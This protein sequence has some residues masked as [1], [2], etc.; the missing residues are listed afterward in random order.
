MTATLGKQG[1]LSLLADDAASETLVDPSGVSSLL[2]DGQRDRRF[3]RNASMPFTVLRMLDDG[4]GG[5]T[6][7]SY[8]VSP[9]NLPDD[10]VLSLKK[11]LTSL[12]GVR[13]EFVSVVSL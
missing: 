7:L 8:T 13:D 12:S 5:G 11:V 3:G 1:L 9:E 10:T 4:R 6:E 2:S